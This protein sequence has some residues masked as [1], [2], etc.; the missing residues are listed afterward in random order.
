MVVTAEQ[1]V[2]RQHNLPAYHVACKA[3]MYK[4]Q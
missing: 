1:I 4:H 3:P 2:Y